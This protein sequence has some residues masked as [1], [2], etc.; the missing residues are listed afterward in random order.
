MKTI[1]ECAIVRVNMSAVKAFDSMPPYVRLV[2]QIV[3]KGNG[4]VYVSLIPDV[5]A[6][7]APAVAYVRSWHGDLLGD[8]RVPMS[9]LSVVT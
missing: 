4:R 6:I 3:R 1:T 2:Q 7:G 9:A 8:V 5:P